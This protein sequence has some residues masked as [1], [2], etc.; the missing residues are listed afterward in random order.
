MYLLH[1]VDI[2]FCCL[3]FVGFFPPLQ[4]QHSLLVKYQGLVV[5]Q[6]INQTKKTEQGDGDE[7]EEDEGADAIRKELQ[8][9]T[10]S[11]KDLVLRPRK[12]SVTEE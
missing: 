8:E 7:T 2:S 11:I 3:F 4:D 5:K 9:I 1:N 6:L 10:T 12:S